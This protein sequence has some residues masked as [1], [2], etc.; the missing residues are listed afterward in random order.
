MRSAPG[1]LKSRFSGDTTG[2]EGDV[3]V[4]AVDMTVSCGGRR[5]LRSA[6]DFG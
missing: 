4:A 3:S 6:Q 5:L 2:P 1:K